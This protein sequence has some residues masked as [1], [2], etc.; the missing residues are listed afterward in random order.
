MRT[1]KRAPR[2]PSHSVNGTAVIEWKMPV[3]KPHRPRSEPKLPIVCGAPAWNKA[4]KAHY[5]AAA[6]EPIP[7]DFMKLI[8][9]LAKTIRK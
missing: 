2:N 3:R 5:D 4:I 9:G 7:A 1:D 6:A 8:A